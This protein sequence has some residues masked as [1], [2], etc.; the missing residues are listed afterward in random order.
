MRQPL[1]RT[2][3]SRRVQSLLRGGG[4]NTICEEARCPNRNHCYSRGTATFLILG[5]VCTRSCPFCS[6]AGGIP[7][8]PDPEEPRKLIEATVALG[9]RHVVITS[10]NR[11]DLADQGSGHFVECI[12]GL[13][14]EIDGICVEL[15]IPDFRGRQED[16]DRVLDARP[17]ILN[18]NIET[19]P[20]L[21]RKVRP[22]AR[23]QRSLDL[24]ER[25]RE[26]AAEGNWVKSGL[27]LGLG[28][29][30]SEVDDLLVD[31]Q[32]HGVQI[33]TIGQ[34]LQPTP[35]SLP[36]YEY[37][38]PERFERWQERGMEMGF[39]LVFAGPFVR[40]SYMADAQVPLP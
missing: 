2:A 31:L 14:A 24:L 5:D 27:M 11:D 23:Y 15:L 35:E 9:L 33:I 6:V 16:I 20:S 1:S 12:E 29:T 38:E 30:E 7:L 8:P 3:S 32:R 10:V 21:Y 36:V 39:D 25:A 28:E 13:R 34:Y 4:L 26:K 19:V 18:H 22:G 40:S 37:V 17:D